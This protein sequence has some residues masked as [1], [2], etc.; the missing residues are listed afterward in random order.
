MSEKAASGEH[1]LRAAGLRIT[2]QRKLILR[3]LT[4]SSQHLDANDIYE[5]GRL[6]DERLSLSTVYRTLAIL[7]ETGLVRELHLDGEQ[8]HY[9]LDAKDNHSHLV[10]LDCG[11]VV[12]VDSEAFSQAASAAARAAGFA[13]VRAQVQLTGYCADC[14]LRHEQAASTTG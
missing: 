3:I 14:R 7:K 1:Q 5:L 11:L 4:N 8:H 6:K 12:E 2:P 10:C 9:E 13:I